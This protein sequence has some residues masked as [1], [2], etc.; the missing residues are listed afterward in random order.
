[1]GART[2]EQFLK[3]LK[4]TSREIWLGKEQV[5]DV[6]DHPEFSQAA[7]AMA[8]WY[9]L[10]FEYPDELLIPDPE[11]GEQINISHMI[12]TSKDDLKRR[13]VG[14]TRISE[15]SMGVMGRLPDYMNV[16]FAGFA[17]NPSDWR[18][19]S[20]ENEEGCHN[21]VE[22]Q[23]RLRRNDLS[24]THTI[25]HPVV[26]KVK[27]S[28]FANNPVPLH[29]VGETKNSII[30][31][32]ARLLATL[33]PFA[34]EQTVYPGHPLP[35]DAPDEYAISF[36]VPMDAP[37]LVFIC[38]DSGARPNV[39]GFDAPFSTRFDEQDAYCI[40]DDVEVPKDQVWINGQKSVYNTVMMPSSWWPNIM[41]QTTIRALTKLEFSYGLCNRMA[42]IVNDQSPAA[43]D[44][45]AEIL[46]YIELTRNSLIAAVEEAK[47]YPD[48]GVFPNARALTSIRAIMP[49]WMTRVNEIIKT[50]GS[51]NLL[52]V[53]SK[54]QL[55]DPRLRPLL[56][57]FLPGANGVGPEER[58]AVYRTA[59]DFVGS[60]FGARNELYERNYLASTRTNR[61]AQQMFYSQANKERGKELL[62]KVLRDARGR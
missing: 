45:L 51:H 14:L 59:W 38:R 2:G 61:M 47:T 41:Q 49:I 25:V 54:A 23:K 42:E 50:I 46:G 44:M 53:A 1:M 16:T 57:E 39:D 34:D 28:N 6:V 35:A 37:G 58:S 13:A 17:G 62:D 32:G 10:Q 3:G 4:A 5:S 60:A 48:G 11:T 56:E 9:D 19:A 12:P 36:T 15:I 21:M 8:S 29:K 52:A 20:N 7:Q 30:V 24:L 27:D 43:V 40:F 26:D 18:G 33:A 55:E 31:R 22:F